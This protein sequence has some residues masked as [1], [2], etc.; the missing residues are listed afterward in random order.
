LST[1]NDY[2]A[3]TAAERRP[4]FGC[5]VGRDSCSRPDLDPIENFMDYTDD[6]C[7]FQFTAGQDQRMDARFSTYRL[8]Q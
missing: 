5:P 3:D 4:A 2:I 6:A 1:K 7:L 8:G